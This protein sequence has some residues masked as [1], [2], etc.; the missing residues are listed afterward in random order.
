MRKKQQ[1]LEKKK[2]TRATLHFHR[3]RAVA[4]YAIK[5]K[6]RSRLIA[7]SIA[8]IRGTLKPIFLSQQ[9]KYRHEPIADGCVRKSSRQA[10]A[11]SYSTPNATTSGA[12]KAKGKKDEKNKPNA[13]FVVCDQLQSVIEM[14]AHTAW[15]QHQAAAAMATSK[16]ATQKRAYF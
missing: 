8:A 10:L 11:L 3:S 16:M 13:P 7:R 2:W 1:S 12:Q 14:R 15:T 6:M 5:K 4:A 9:Q